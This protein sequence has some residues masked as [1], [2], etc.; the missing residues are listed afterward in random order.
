MDFVSQMGMMPWL[1]ACGFPVSLQQ[2]FIASELKPMLSQKWCDARLD[3]QARDPVPYT[4]TDIL[5][6]RGDFFGD[7]TTLL[8]QFGDPKDVWVY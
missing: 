2:E 7:S 5:Q 4:V 1:V 3:L 8:I 6:I